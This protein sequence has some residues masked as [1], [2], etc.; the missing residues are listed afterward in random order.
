METDLHSANNSK[1][2][3]LYYSSDHSSTETWM[4]SSSVGR[5]F[6]VAFTARH[7]SR[8]RAHCS[9]SP[10]SSTAM[11]LQALGE[12]LLRKGFIR[13]L[14]PGLTWG[15]TFMMPFSHK[16]RYFSFVEMYEKWRGILCFALY[17]YRQSGELEIMCKTRRAMWNIISCHLSTGLL[18]SVCGWDY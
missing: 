3:I 18:L 7:F 10:Q 17:R 15:F 8:G 11:L 13:E 16:R 5:S 2:D 9:C 12:K 1:L 14:C 6:C 4:S